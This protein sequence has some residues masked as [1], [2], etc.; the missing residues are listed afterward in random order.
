VKAWTVAFGLLV[1]A[2]QSCVDVNGGAVELS[3]AIRRENGTPGS[4]A[5]AGVARIQLCARQEGQPDAP[6]APVDEWPCETY[7]GTTRFDIP[8]GRYAFSI[9]P[10][11]R[12]GA[13]SPHPNTRVPAPIVR[14]IT[15]GDVAELDALLIVAGDANLVCASLP[16]GARQPAAAD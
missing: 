10:I 16:S 5:E 15:E 14:D 9:V 12:S 11:C 2:L 6:C 4:C 3:W 13:E 8:P 7:R 1:L